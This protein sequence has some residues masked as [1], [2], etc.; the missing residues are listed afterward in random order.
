MMVVLKSS[1][2]GWNWILTVPTGIVRTMTAVIRSGATHDANTLY[3]GALNV[4]PCIWL[5]PSNIDPFQ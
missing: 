3:T 4:A 2:D 5:T 1:G